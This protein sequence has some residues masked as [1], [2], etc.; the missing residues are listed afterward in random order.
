MRGHVHE[1][2]R[3]R[4]HG[5]RLAG[6]FALQLLELLEVPQMMDMCVRSEFQSAN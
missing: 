4:M 5:R 1:C 6:R 3:A 2:M